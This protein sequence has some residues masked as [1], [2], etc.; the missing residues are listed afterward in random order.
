M[1][2][3]AKPRYETETGVFPT[4]L[5][6]LMEERNVTQRQL[7]AVVGMRPQTISLYIGGQSVPDINCLKK[8]ADFFDVQADYLIDRTEVQSRDLDVQNACSCTGISEK[9][10]KSLQKLTKDNAEAVNAILAS[11]NFGKF[12]EYIV[13]SVRYADNRGIL[14]AQNIMA[15]LK[16]EESPFPAEDMENLFK[17]GAKE[18]SRKL[19][20]EVSKHLY[21]IGIK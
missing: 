8:I 3:K 6:G 12:I 17:F 16:E 19:F 10:L 20:E 7:A 14:I 15:R 1:T 13:K 21:E 9:A 2:R 4:R 11:P 18:A 5:R